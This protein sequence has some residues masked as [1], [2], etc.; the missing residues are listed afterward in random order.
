MAK[1]AVTA[2][3]AATDAELFASALG[4]ESAVHDDT[5]DRSLEQQDDGLEGQ[6]ENVGED[7]TEVE[8]EAAAEGEEGDGETEIEAKDK[9]EGADKGPSKDPKTGKFV[10]ADAK[11]KPEGETDGEAKP[12][13]GG[14]VPPARL[15]EATE[16]TKA[17]EAKLAESDKR[18]SELSNKFDVVLRQLELSRQPQPQP[19]AK[20][21]AAARPDKFADPDGYDKWVEDRIA[22]VR[23]ETSEDFTKRLINMNLAN[24]RETHGEKFDAAYQAIVTAAEVDPEARNSIQRIWNSANPGAELMRWHRNRET[25]QRVGGD[26][27][28][29]EQK[30]RD[31]TRAALLADPEFRKEIIASLKEEAGGKNGGIPRHVVRAAAP[32]RQIPSLNGASGSSHLSDQTFDDQSDEGFFERALQRP[33]G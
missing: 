19:A 21:E 17:A 9:D 8:T 14:L 6:V 30:L 32:A 24:T 18:F 16:K 29:Y 11:E 10:K 28:A 1:D 13:K 23:N 33:A 22:S 4:G 7:E 2:A 15:R 26:P 20:T 31:D 27:E 5:N 12:E 25:L 3:I